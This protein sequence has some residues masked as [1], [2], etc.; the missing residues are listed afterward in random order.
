VVLVQSDNPKEPSRQTVQSEQTLEYVLPPGSAITLGGSDPRVI[1]TNGPL[2]TRPGRQQV[3]TLPQAVPV[4]MISKDRTDTT[5]GAAQ[6]DTVR[7]W[8]GKAANLHPV[9]W[10][11][12]VMMTLVAGALVYFGW[13]T[14]AA[15]AEAVGIAMIVLA[16]ML[17]DRGMVIFLGGIGTFAFIALLVLYSY[18]KGLWDQ[19]KNG[20]PDFLES[21]GT[22]PS[23]SGASPL[24][25]PAG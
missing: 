25:R 1:G 24:P 22:V 6:R 9:M 3:V 5:I 19:N 14:K 18:Y 15:V 13:Y 11:G 21:K 17:P 8:A 20:I 12:I 2:V 4:R 16:Q 23:P 7:E 10:A